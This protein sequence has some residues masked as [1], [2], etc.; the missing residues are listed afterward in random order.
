MTDVSLIM[1]VHNGGQWLEECL[2]S[3]VSQT[4]EGRVELS[5]YN[6]GSKDETLDILKKWK[7][8]LE[9]RG[10]TVIISGHED[11][12][13][14]GVGFAKNRAVNQSTGRCLCFLD[15]DDVMH[16]NR[17]SRQYSA[18]CV[19]PS[20]IVGC[21]FHREPPDSTKRFTEWANSLSPMQLYTQVY[22][23]HGPTVIM[24]TWCCMRQVFDR[25]GGFDEGGKGVP[26]DLIFFY[27]HLE[28]GGQIVRVDQD[29]LMYRYHPHAT[30]FSIEEDTIWAVRVAFIQRQV[31]D[32]STHFSIWSVGKQGKRFFRSLSPANQAKVQMF[33]DV[34]EKKIKKQF[35]TYEKSKR[36]KPKIPIVHFSQV[37]PPVIICVKMNLT[38]G[39]FEENLS[40]LNL[41]EGEDYFHFN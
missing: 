24:P 31:L 17:I 3:V 23:S 36:P 26:E 16:P 10:I 6:D 41:V 20:A 22:T 21:K 25:V 29:L 12:V 2:L 33:C 32:S 40:S 18:S 27:H 1:P 14:R 8:K 19:H 38:G 7:Y 37:K 28:L 5:V 9:D 30:T 34:D 15:A 35:Y 4:F 13:P 11:E 39:S